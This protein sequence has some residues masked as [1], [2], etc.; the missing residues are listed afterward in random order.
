MAIFTITI[1]AASPSFV[2]E[3]VLDGVTWRL[4]FRWN[5]RDEY[6]YLTVS[7]VDDE[8]IVASRRLVAGAR[9]LRYV[10]QDERPAGE[11]FVLDTPTRDDLGT[12]A[13]LVYADAEEIAAL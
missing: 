12:D 8:V 13:L 10:V 7:N 11:L 3:N 9:L 1:D 5:A 4:L 6:W 2:Q